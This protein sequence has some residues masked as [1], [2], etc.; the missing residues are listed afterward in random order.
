MFT[1]LKSLISGGSTGGRPTQATGAMPAGYFVPRT[2]SE[3]FTIPQRKLL[4]RQIWDNTSLPE[5]VYTRLY[6]EPLNTL[7][8][9]VQNVPACEDGE[10]SREGGYLDLTLKFTACSVRLAKG[11]MFPPGAAPEEQA[12]KNTLW[13][14]VVFWIALTTHLS[15]LTRVNGELLNGQCWMPGLARPPVPYRFRLGESTHYETATLMAVRLLPASAISWLSGDRKAMQVM[16]AQ[17]GGNF[18]TMPVIKDILDKAR[19]ITGAPDGTLPVTTSSVISGGIPASIPAITPSLTS[20]AVDLAANAPH[21]P[22]IEL[23]SAI[24]IGETNLQSQLVVD[25]DSS[26]LSISDN[27]GTRNEQPGQ[28]VTGD[29]DDTALLLS[30]FSATESNEAPSDEPIPADSLV[31]VELPEIAAAFTDSTPVLK[32]NPDVL[33]SQMPGIDEQVLT[34]ESSEIEQ[35]IINVSPEIIPNHMAYKEVHTGEAFHNWLKDSV[36]KKTISVNESDSLLHAVSGFMFISL[37]GAV[38]KFI[39][40][41]GSTKSRKAIQSDFE[42]SGLLHMRNEQRFFKVRIYES[43]GLEGKF[44]KRSGY[45]IKLSEVYGSSAIKIKDSRYL[46]IEN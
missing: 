2:A 22:E 21:S 39:E 18:S 15:L 9:C 34:N 20:N 13:N 28:E 3:L 19:Q 11:H 4:L 16:A 43:E 12:A 32:N 37:P 10:W 35:E 38:F 33:H 5:E 1:K 30:M 36:N 26:S 31:E 42:K 29:D 46:L 17:L 40:A 6:L 44:Q 27:A 45:L 23:T 24:D 25:N 41:T 7:A 14:A 8:E